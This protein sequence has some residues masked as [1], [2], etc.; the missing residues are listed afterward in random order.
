MGLIVGTA[1]ESELLAATGIDSGTGAEVMLGKSPDRRA[2]D[3]SSKL[4]SRSH[5]DL[6]SLVVLRKSAIVLPIVLAICGNFRGPRKINAM[7]PIRIN[8]EVPIDSR[9][10]K[11]T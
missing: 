7:I 6:N 3:S 10:N 5:V 4:T 2:S 11:N 1:S 9:I 8:S